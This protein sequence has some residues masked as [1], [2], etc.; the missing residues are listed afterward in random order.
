M[1]AP[2]PPRRFPFRR[3]GRSHRPATP[4]Q[5]LREDLRNAAS[6]RAEGSSVLPTE[7]PPGA[8]SWG[9]VP[10]KAKQDPSVTAGPGRGPPCARVGCCCPFS[11]GARGRR[12]E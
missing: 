1:T 5:G 12:G 3:R 6:H 7:I 11:R 8:T 4:G 9:E 10:A 2:R